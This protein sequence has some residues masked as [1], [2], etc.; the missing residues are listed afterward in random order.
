M[1][2]VRHV[3]MLWLLG[4]TP[5]VLTGCG[6]SGGGG[7][8]QRTSCLTLQ[9]ATADQP[10]STGLRQTATP[11]HLR[12]MLPGSPG[13]IT[14]LDIRI[15]AADIATP[16]TSSRTLTETEQSEVTVILSVPLGTHRRILVTAFNASGAKIFQGETTADLTR[17]LE[18][19]PL[20]LVRVLLPE[21]VW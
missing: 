9:L 21:L 5:C 3:G 12:Q 13:F 8:A 16:I 19:V 14:R 10:A 6:S 11:R 18:V 4:I 2:R 7:S 1:P 20:T 15:E 17:D